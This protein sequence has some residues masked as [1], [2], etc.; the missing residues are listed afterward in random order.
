MAWWLASTSRW[1]T[2]LPSTQLAGDFGTGPT[3][4]HLPQSLQKAN[5]SR[6]GL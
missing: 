6:P 5:Q 2:A 4:P 3:K 1:R